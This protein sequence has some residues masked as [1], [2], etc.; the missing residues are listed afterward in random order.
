MVPPHGKSKEEGQHFRE[1]LSHA[2]AAV[3]DHPDPEQY[4]RHLRA[5][6]GVDWAKGLKSRDPKRV[7]VYFTKH[8]G[9][10]HKQYQHV[11]PAEWQ[12]PGQGPG[13]FWGRWG[14]EAARVGVRVSPQDGVKVGRLLR[15]WAHAQGTTRQVT[16]CRTRGGEAQSAYGEVIGLAGAQVLASRKVRYRNSRVRVN[17]LPDNRGWVSVNDGAAFASQIARWLDQ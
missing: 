11:V 7:A 8:N 15:R 16:V 13:R 17:R 2:W 6:T 3:V 9:M 5:G 14:L 12:E 10:S 1:W 4:R